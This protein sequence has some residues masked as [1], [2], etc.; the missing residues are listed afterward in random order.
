MTTKEKKA[1]LRAEARQWRKIAKSFA[2]HPTLDARIPASDDVL[3][4]M[5]SRLIGHRWAMAA[6]A[7]IEVVESAP[8]T[9]AQVVTADVLCALFLALECEDEAKEP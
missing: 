4:S 6:R 5:W 7:R 2:E 9:Y 3:A 8:T 1:L